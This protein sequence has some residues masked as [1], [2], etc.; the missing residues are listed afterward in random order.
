MKSKKLIKKLKL[1]NFLSYGN[2]GE[3]IELQ[4]LNV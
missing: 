2:Q 4:A 3:E 1:K